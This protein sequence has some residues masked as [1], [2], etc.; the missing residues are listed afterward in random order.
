MKAK[1]K[2]E[3]HGDINP[4]HGGYLYSLH[5]ARDGWG[6][7]NV[8]RIFPCVDAGL[9]ENEFWVERL[10]VNLPD[11]PVTE[12][13]VLSVIGLSLAE[14][15][16]EINEEMRLCTMLDACLAY[17]KYDKD[18]DDAVR[19]GKR[20]RLARECLEDAVVNVQLR[21]NATIINYARQVARTF[22]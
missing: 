19:I 6:Y 14:Y 10:T 7:I 16:A 2:I 3:Y 18:G 8:V 11:D 17:G 13:D 9:A 15:E 20:D 12:A 1:R 22:I 4:E 5:T 21:G